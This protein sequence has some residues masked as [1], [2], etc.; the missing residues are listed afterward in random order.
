MK[1][2]F[3]DSQLKHLPQGYTALAKAKNLVSF[4][5]KLTQT[6]LL[7]SIIPSRLL[8]VLSLSLSLSLSLPLFSVPV[9]SKSSNGKKKH[10]PMALIIEPARELAQQ[11][12]DN[13]T[14]F[15]KYLPTK[16]KYVTQKDSS[17]LD[18]F[19]T[20]TILRM[21]NNFFSLTSYFFLV[22]LFMCRELLVMGGDS[23]KEQI[24]ALQEGVDI[25][26]GTPG[27]LDDLIST[28]KLDL[29]G[30]RYISFV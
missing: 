28:G 30:V 7:P 8:H 21:Y 13:I 22:C 19:S 5:G 29:S 16:L 14:R 1:F 27:R 6:V 26:C 23:A 25:V 10:V 12:H 2:N 20:I 24:R 4:E 9:T 15:K 3:G 18:K 11:T 17:T